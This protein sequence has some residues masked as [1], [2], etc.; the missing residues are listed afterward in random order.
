[1]SCAFDGLRSNLLEKI[2]LAPKRWQST[3]CVCRASD[4]RFASITYQNR[5]FIL[6]IGC[7]PRPDGAHRHTVDAMTPSLCYR[8]IHRTPCQSSHYLS[9][10]PM[11]NIQGHFFVCQ[12]LSLKYKKCWCLIGV[13]LKE[14]TRRSE[15]FFT[16]VLCTSF[17][18]SGWC[19]HM[20]SRLMHLQKITFW[21]AVQCTHLYTR[22]GSNCKI[23]PNTQVAL[24]SCRF[25]KPQFQINIRYMT[26]NPEYW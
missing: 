12:F 10:L 24:Q 11:Q 14:W 15:L 22:N 6:L 18:C 8:A 3:W 21:I 13:P 20:P 7:W 4:L 2:W 23:T 26:F 9:Y 25:F 19:V 5:R 16:P 1:M 17:S